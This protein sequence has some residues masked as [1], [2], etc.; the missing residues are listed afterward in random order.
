MEANRTG[1]Y[2]LQ[3]AQRQVGE[4]QNVMRDNLTK[5]IER[6][7]KLDDLDAKAEDLEAE[8]QR[9][10]N[11]AGRLRRQMWWQNKRNQLLIGGVIL[12]IIAVIVIIVATR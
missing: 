9:F 12:A 5:V 1:D 7:E 3:E 10:Q 4:V 2:R 11:R 6:G 8:G